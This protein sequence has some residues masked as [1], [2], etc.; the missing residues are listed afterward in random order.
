M[1]WICQSRWA[2]ANLVPIE[3]FDPFAVGSLAR[4]DAVSALINLDYGR[5]KAIMAVRKA[6][7][8]LGADAPV[9]A[10]IRHALADVGT[11]NLKRKHT[12]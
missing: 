6:A 3:E 9:A 1:T 11:V 12:A 5:L 10:L 2:A 7:E 4:H 8:I